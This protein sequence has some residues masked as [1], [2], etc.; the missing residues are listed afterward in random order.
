MY[1]YATYQE[2]VRLPQNYYNAGVR[3]KLSAFVLRG[4]NQL[5]TRWYLSIPT[6]LLSPIFGASTNCQDASDSRSVKPAFEFRISDIQPV[7]ESS[8]VGPACV[9][10]LIFVDNDR[11][12]LG[13]YFSSPPD[14]NAGQDFRRTVRS[15]AT[16]VTFDTEA[17]KVAKFKTW[18]GL[19]GEPAVSGKLRILPIGKGNFIAGVHDII[20]RFSPDFEI[21]AERLLRPEG[22]GIN[23]GLHEDY[24]SLHA[25][26]KGRSAMLMRFSTELTERD[27]WISPLT[28]HDEQRLDELPRYVH[29]ISIIVDQT[30][31]SNWNHSDGVSRPITVEERGTQPRPLC[32]ECIGAISATLGR[33]LI[34]LATHPGASYLVVDTN[35][36]VILRQS[37]PGNRTSAVKSSGGADSNRAAISYFDGGI[38]EGGILHFAVVDADAHKEIWEHE[39]KMVLEKSRVGPFQATAFA[40][41]VIALSPNGHK[42]AILTSGVVQVYFI[43]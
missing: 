19:A 26:V 41:P 27:Y 37:H 36:N 29:A 1:D 16:I 15:N 11:L 20:F 4:V 25:D 30:L 35:G 43:P 14:P 12:A 38:P 33:N 18:T 8:S 2:L 6:I 9:T 3:I 40:P 42:L 34:L 10:N 28:L 17:G 24:W 32:A 7:H 13:M 31:F 5:K 23:D 22:A 39:Q 21:Q